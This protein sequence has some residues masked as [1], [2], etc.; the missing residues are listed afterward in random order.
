MVLNDTERHKGLCVL[1]VSEKNIFTFTQS[2]L[3]YRSV[4][5]ERKRNVATLYSMIITTNINVKKIAYIR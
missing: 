4:K 1:K 3:P 5:K 2:L